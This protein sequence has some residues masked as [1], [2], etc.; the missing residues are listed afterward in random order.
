MVRVM[1]GLNVA[2]AHLVLVDSE[3][4]S[5]NFCRTHSVFSAFV[6]DSRFVQQSREH[7]YAHLTSIPYLCTVLMVQKSCAEDL[8]KDIPNN[9]CMAYL[10]TFTIK[11]CQMWVN[12]PHMDDMGTKSPERMGL[13][14][15]YQL[16]QDFGTINRNRLEN[17]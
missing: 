4:L 9:P 16:V 3:F 15:E 14:Y 10:P 8:Q 6:R 17:T 7:I 5:S 2:V 1:S 11:I 13:N 12:I